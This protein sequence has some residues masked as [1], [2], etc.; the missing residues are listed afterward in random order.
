MIKAVAGGGGR[1]IRPAQSR[2]ELIKGLKMA[3]S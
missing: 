3:R 1:G 2:D